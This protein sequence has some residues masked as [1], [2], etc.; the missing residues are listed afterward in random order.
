MCYSVFL[1]SVCIQSFLFVSVRGISATLCGGFGSFFA[2]ETNKTTMEE[3][4]KKTM[5]S[6]ISLSVP[7]EVEV[8]E[9][10]NWYEAK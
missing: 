6:A 3:I 1:L 2:D 4:L 8:S 9:A 10:K 5:E 7:L